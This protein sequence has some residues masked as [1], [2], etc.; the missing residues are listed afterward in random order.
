M[1]SVGGKTKPSNVG[2]RKFPTNKMQNGLQRIPSTL[3]TNYSKS[4][5]TKTDTT[6]KSGKQTSTQ[7]KTSFQSQKTATSQPLVAKS[8]LKLQL[9]NARNDSTQMKQVLSEHGIPPAKIVKSRKV[10]ARR[11]KPPTEFTIYQNVLTPMSGNQKRPA[12]KAKPVKVSASKLAPKQNVGSKTSK[13]KRK[14]SAKFMRNSQF[15]REMLRN[16]QP[17]KDGRFPYIETHRKGV[18]QEPSEY[19][20]SS[21]MLVYQ[22]PK[23]DIDYDCEHYD[24]TTD[25]ERMTSFCNSYQSSNE[26][27]YCTSCL[28]SDADDELSIFKRS[29]DDS[30]DLT[31]IDKTEALLQKLE[32]MFDIKGKS[33]S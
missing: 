5:K 19:N 16:L 27:S 17:L 4:T 14:S 9:W 6:G 32:K 23:I 22:N 3:S 26:D 21:S 24:S 25:F 30:K 20:R 11:I 10:G 12:M 7:G 31:A 18:P 8:N 28:S 29:Y 33:N 2:A 13:K 1:P 15:Q